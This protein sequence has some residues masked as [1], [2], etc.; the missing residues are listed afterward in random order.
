MNA[1]IKKLIDSTDE[2]F[3]AQLMVKL[4]KAGEF[5]EV[6]EIKKL[7]NFNIYKNHTFKNQSNHINVFLESLASND[8]KFL[9]EFLNP[10]PNLINI[11]NLFESSMNE[12]IENNYDNTLKVLSRF[13][14]LSYINN[15]SMCDKT[16]Y[17]NLILKAH[18]HANDEI[19]DIIFANLDKEK[20]T[21][22]KM[23]KLSIFRVTKGQTKYID[24]F[25][26]DFLQKPIAYCDDI[27]QDIIPQKKHELL[28]LSTDATLMSMVLKHKTIIYPLTTLLLDG[29]QLG[30]ELVKNK[31]PQ[32]D[33]QKQLNHN[34]QLHEFIS[35]NFFTNS[36]VTKNIDSIIEQE[37]I[38]LEKN[39]LES[40]I[41]T[42]DYDT[43][44][45][46]KI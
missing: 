44:I 23:L 26:L 5:N 46:W 34:I 15:E 16:T 8:E 33:Y 6:L 21:N 20:K 17:N 30:Y 42:K 37:K 43:S 32:E 31:L 10:T 9:E 4:I 11:R 13:K 14:I 24:S 25:N 38:L 7:K 41:L 39:N 29:N 2:F 19:L 3:I 35:Q 1:L 40:I 12:I 36:A 45:K 27:Y 28:E 18:L 22:L